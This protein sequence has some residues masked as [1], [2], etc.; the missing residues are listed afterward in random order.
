MAH[1]PSRGNQTVVQRVLSEMQRVAKPGGVI[2]TRDISAHDF[3]PTHDLVNLINRTMF[4][5][6]GLQGWYGH[7]MPR[8]Y[9]NIGLDLNTNNVIVNTTSS[10]WGPAVGEHNWYSRYAEKLGE[11]SV[12]REQWVKAGVSEA[13]IDLI[14]KRL[15]LWGG[16]GTALYT[17]LFVEI[18]A[19]KDCDD[20]TPET[21]SDTDIELP[22][23]Q[24]DSGQSPHAVV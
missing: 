11:H 16:S 24:T 19:R 8:L 22:G 10:V 21:D 15:E 13:V 4:R 12:A 18:I 6:C 20:M 3:Y 17:C 7:V 14:I 1:L 2:A 9:K 5:A 23:L